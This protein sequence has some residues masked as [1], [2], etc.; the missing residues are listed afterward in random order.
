MKISLHD[1]YASNHFNHHASGMVAHSCGVLKKR[2]A[3]TRSLRPSDADL[4]GFWISQQAF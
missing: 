3:K 2:F 4:K 1:D